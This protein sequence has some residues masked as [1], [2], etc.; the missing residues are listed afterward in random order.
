MIVLVCIRERDL[1][2]KVETYIIQFINSTKGLVINYGEGTGLQNGKITSRKLFA[3][4]LK[5]GY[6]F[7]C[8][9]F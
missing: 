2:V 1:I 3:P 7:V 9:P 8:P 5:T 6:N 4:P